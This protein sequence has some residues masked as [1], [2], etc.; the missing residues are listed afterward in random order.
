MRKARLTKKKLKTRNTTL[1]I[2]SKKKMRMTRLN[3]KMTKGLMRTMGKKTK[4]TRLS[5]QMGKPSRNWKM[6]SQSWH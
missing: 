5:G 3:L 6:T 2:L 1:T 4:E